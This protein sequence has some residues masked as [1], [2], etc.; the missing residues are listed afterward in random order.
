MKKTK[1]LMPVTHMDASYREVLEALSKEIDVLYMQHA[2][3]N[4]VKKPTPEQTVEADAL[5]GPINKL[6]SDWNAMV[7]T[8]VIDRAERKRCLIA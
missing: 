1:P 7:K 4:D 2:V 3:L 8:C 6:E 5:T